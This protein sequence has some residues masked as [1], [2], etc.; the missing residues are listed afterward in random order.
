MTQEN[1]KKNPELDVGGPHKAAGHLQNTPSTRLPLAAAGSQSALDV[2]ASRK[3]P[4]MWF[5]RENKFSEGQRLTKTK[6]QVLSD[7]G[8]RDLGF[9]PLFDAEDRPLPWTVVLFLPLAGFRLASAIA[10][11]MLYLLTLSILIYTECIVG[12]I[13]RLILPPSWE[14]MQQL[15][16]LLFTVQ[17]TV[18]QL[19]GY[20]IMRCLGFEIKIHGK[21]H[22][23][24]VV[25]LNHPF[26]ICANHSSLLDT[27]ALAS[28]VGPYAAVRSGFTLNS[29]QVITVHAG[30]CG[31]DATRPIHWSNCQA[32]AMHLCQAG[33][34]MWAGR[35]GV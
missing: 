10:A 26:V 13:I 21:Q 1:R 11:V 33:L 32:L 19:C 6:R 29:S 24:N 4:R 17:V 20:L 25:N 14:S 7:F 35:G 22:M 18:T 8:G 5:I 9:N 31:L 2:L 3:L 16:Q 23:K 15:Q 34:A 30:C 12:Y 28:A 27:P